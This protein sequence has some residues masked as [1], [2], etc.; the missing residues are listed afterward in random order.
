MATKKSKDET[1]NES[2]EDTVS[3]NEEL[4]EDINSKID[5]KKQNQ[6]NA[7]NENKDND[8]TKED[9]TEENDIDNNELLN[10]SFEDLGL[11][12]WLI[13]ATNNLSMKKPTEIQS[14]CIP[15]ILAGNIY[16]Y[17]LEIHLDINNSLF[18]I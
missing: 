10:K 8:N 12:S 15:E 4:N 17:N 14:A 16:I 11:S 6:I 7:N 18:I 2:N 9:A 3:K 13:D 1:L 5:E